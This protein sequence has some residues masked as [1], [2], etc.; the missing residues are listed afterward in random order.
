[1]N[2]TRDYKNVD[3][4]FQA[5]EL[6][7]Y[8]EGI[9][10]YYF[11]RKHVSD[12]KIGFRF[13]NGSKLNILEEDLIKINQQNKKPKIV[14]IIDK[15]KGGLDVAKRIHMNFKNDID[16]VYTIDEI[17]NVEISDDVEKYQLENVMAHF[18]LIPKDL[19]SL[20]DRTVLE[21]VPES[22]QSDKIAAYAYFHDFCK[23]KEA[24]DFIEK[25]IR[26]IA[27]IDSQIEK[28]RMNPKARSAKNARNKTY[29]A[30][31]VANDDRLIE[32]KTELSYR[33][34]VSKDAKKQITK[35]L[36]RVKNETKDK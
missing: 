27:Q 8:L 23:S 31:I 12:T 21:G 18:K 3:N 35:F 20:L 13:I 28:G 34:K 30:R 10:D 2:Q 33:S 14:F 36:K 16:G 9:E 7:V 32:Y 15:D 22:I 6:I 26:R 25:R 17:L 11:F 29:M 24:K 4:N 5:Y 1:M 19:A